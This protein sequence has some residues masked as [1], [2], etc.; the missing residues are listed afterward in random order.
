MVEMS[1]DNAQTFQDLTDIPYSQFRGILGS[2]LVIA[3]NNTLV[4]I[5]G[6]SR[7]SNSTLKEGNLKS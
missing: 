1:T 5:G 7:S 6:R 4:V 3:D 2:C